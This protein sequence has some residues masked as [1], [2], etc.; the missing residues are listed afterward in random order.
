ML[1]GKRNNR[2]QDGAYAYARSDSDFNQAFDP[3]Q[4]LQDTRLTLGLSVRCPTLP[5]S[6]DLRGRAVKLVGIAL[7]EVDNTI[8][9]GT[10]FP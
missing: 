8:W 2:A 7:T 4:P 6:E 5:V 10:H 1:D 3:F 9:Q